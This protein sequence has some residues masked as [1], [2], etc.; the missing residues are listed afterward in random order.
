MEQYIFSEKYLRP[1]F[2]HK[3][4]IIQRNVYYR[5]LF[6]ITVTE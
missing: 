4:F 5:Y 3:N 1:R 6:V 2:C